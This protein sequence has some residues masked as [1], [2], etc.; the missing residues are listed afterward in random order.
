MSGRADGYRRALGPRRAIGVTRRDNG[1]RRSD[2][3]GFR[4][5]GGFRCASR[6]GRCVHDRE[7]RKDRRGCR[8]GRVSGRRG[9]GGH[10]RRVSCDAGRRNLCRHG[11]GNGRRQGIRP[12]P[13]SRGHAGG[14][15]I[16]AVRAA[17]R[18]L[19]VCGAGCLRRGLGEGGDRDRALDAGRGR[20]DGAGGCSDRGPIRHRKR[21]RRRRG[22][23]WRRCQSQVCRGQCERRHSLRLPGIGRP[24]D[25]GAFSA[26]VTGLS[27]ERRGRRWR[28]RACGRAYGRRQ[29]G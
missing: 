20:H 23:A 21:R 25:R 17:R 6:C 19:E 5:R 16:G 4:R 11:R 28:W 27:A 10:R 26:D 12:N 2:A 13:V 3:E 7:L 14:G 24:S 9:G 29:A 1:C 18:Q 15:A 22:S 8:R